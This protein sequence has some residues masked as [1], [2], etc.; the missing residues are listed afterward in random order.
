MAKAVVNKENILFTRN[1]GFEMKEETTTML[2]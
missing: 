1:L 2:Y